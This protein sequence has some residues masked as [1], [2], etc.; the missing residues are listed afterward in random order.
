ML[1]GSTVSMRPAYDPVSIVIMGVGILLVAALLLFI[2]P[3][4]LPGPLLPLIDRLSDVLPEII[5]NT[6]PSVTSFILI[7]SSREKVGE[8]WGDISK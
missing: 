5:G 7:G 3:A 6:E 2:E 8:R 4:A 1:G